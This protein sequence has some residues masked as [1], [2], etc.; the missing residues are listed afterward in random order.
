MLCLNACVSGIWTGA[1]VIYDRH[2]LSIK[3]NDFKLAADASRALYHDTYFKCEECDIDI[4]AFNRELL[5]TGHLPSYIMSHEAERRLRH[6]PG[7]RRYFNQITVSREED[8]PVIDAWITAK[9][10]SQIVL[11]S[12]I[13]PERFKVLTASRVVYI[14]GDVDIEQGEKVVQIAKEC[15][16]VKKVQSFLRYYVLK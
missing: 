9:S 6:L 2:R 11:D 3:F 1:N 15:A 13:D 7:K 16:E 5:V 12:S 4:A 14:M 8:D 10:R